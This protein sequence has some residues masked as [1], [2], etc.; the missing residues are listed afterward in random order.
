M[1]IP[2]SRRT[3]ILRLLHLAPF[4]ALALVVATAAQVPKHGVVRPLADAKFTADDDLKCLSDVLENG[5]PATGP[6]TFLLK[7]TP[8]CAVPP[9]YHTAEEQ[10]I[11]VQGKVSAGMDGVS[12]MTLEPGGFAMMPSKDVHWFS[13]ASKED[14][15]MFVTF[16][17]TYD[18]VWVKDK[19]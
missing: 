14:C 10:L 7:A 12:P 17:R 16:D 4:V 11:V 6:S 13:C 8:N 1:K 5:D 19:K 3:L 9:H 18:I 2:A 15:L